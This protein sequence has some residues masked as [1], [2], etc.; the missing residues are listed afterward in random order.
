MHDGEQ[1]TG[2]LCELLSKPQVRMWQLQPAIVQNVGRCGDLL[3]FFSHG[4]LSDLSLSWHNNL[5]VA[6][7][8]AE[9][10]KAS[11]VSLSAAE[12]MFGELV[13]RQVSNSA[14]YLMA[15]KLG[16]PADIF[17]SCESAET[18]TAD[19]DIRA[20]GAQVRLFDPIEVVACLR[21]ATRLWIVLEAQTQ[22][23]PNGF[24]SY[25]EMRTYT[26]N[27]TTG[28]K[29]CGDAGSSGSRSRCDG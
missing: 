3:A 25:N 8:D 15:K 4:C 7:Q 21:F 27:I 13:E 17:E 11:T 5:R 14:P 1:S 12:S 18:W 23:Q 16:F 24:F 19:L 2:L 10:A 6:S 29:G 26:T 28:E 9:E 22:T 20:L